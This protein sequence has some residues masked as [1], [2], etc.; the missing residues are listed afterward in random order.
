MLLIDDIKLRASTMLRRVD[1]KRRLDE[2]EAQPKKRKRDSQRI[3]HQTL[4]QEEMLEEA[5]ITENFNLDSLSTSFY[6]TK[7]I[8]EFIYDIFIFFLEKD[9][10]LELEKKQRARF[11]KKRG[12]LGGSFVRYHSTAMPVVA[13]AVKSDSITY[14]LFFFV[15]STY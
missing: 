4:S 9:I 11:F 1:A 8:S 3:C 14:I 6:E 5:R 10:Q 7:I 12:A 15:F 13:P 2:M